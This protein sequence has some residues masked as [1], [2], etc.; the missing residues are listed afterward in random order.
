MHLNADQ[1]LD[2]YLKAHPE[3]VD[4]WNEYQKLQNDPRVT[5]VGKY[6]RRFSIDELAQLLNVFRGEMSVV[7]PR[8]F[9]PEQQGIY[10]SA[11]AHY[12]RVHPGIT[13]MWQISGRNNTP[14]QERA[15]WDEY[16]VRNWSIWL[17]LYVMVRTIGVVLSRKGAF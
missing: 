16:Y 7:G 4:Q 3:Y 12:V 17:D 10:G 8:P 2:G 6:L 14:F 15:Q 11:Y 9:F 1:M 13:G 5:R